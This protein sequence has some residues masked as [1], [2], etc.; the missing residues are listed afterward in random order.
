MVSPNSIPIGVRW[1]A[2]IKITYTGTTGLSSTYQQM[3]L[4]ENAK[5]ATTLGGYYANAIFFDV[6]GG[7]IPS[8]LEN[9]GGIGTGVNGTTSLYWLKM[10]SF[11]SNSTSY[12]STSVSTTYQ[13]SNLITNSPIAE[14]TT[15]LVHSVSTTIFV[16][17]YPTA[18]FN[19]SATGLSGMNYK[20][21]VGMSGVDNGEQVFNYYVNFTAKT[22][23]NAVYGKFVNNTI[24]STW[25]PMFIF[26]P[27]FPSSG[28][29]VIS[30]LGGWQGYVTG[31]QTKVP[32]V[33]ETLFNSG[34]NQYACVGV[35][36]HRHGGLNQQP[37]DLA[38]NVYDLPVG[39][40]APK[41]LATD[42][43]AY[44]QFQFRQGDYFGQ[45]GIA[46]SMLGSGGWL[47]GGVVLGGYAFENRDYVMTGVLGTSQL[48]MFSNYGSVN[49]VSQSTRQTTGVPYLKADVP[50]FSGWL[51]FGVFSGSN[52][53][54]F[55]VR[56]REYVDKMPSAVYGTLY[57]NTTPA[58]YKVVIEDSLGVSGGE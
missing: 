1:Y 57:A 40:Y 28:G 16:G 51:D 25:M 9:I 10:G 34:T 13:Q 33:V 54:F 27:D 6:N 41:S 49:M 45:W 37:V 11:N 52:V 12:Y 5:Y 3:L 36:K 8:W 24:S 22:T 20:M 43:N 19:Y 42:A 4:F 47:G 58:V 53:Q 14:Y 32:E 15:T 29:I 56:A 17:M 55:W 7:Q 23:T 26:K 50:A 44:I 30:S 2:P 48:Q 46:S 38:T 35:V 21:N 31:Y 39:N 18:S